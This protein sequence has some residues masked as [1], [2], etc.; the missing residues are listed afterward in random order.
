MICLPKQISLQI[1]TQKETGNGYFKFE[2]W[3]L[4]FF[5][6]SDFIMKLCIS[7]FHSPQHLQHVLRI[8]HSTKLL[9]HYS[10]HTSALL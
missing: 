7:I 5:D 8:Q 4:F 6:F 3:D 2:L 1:L 9:Q 10:Q